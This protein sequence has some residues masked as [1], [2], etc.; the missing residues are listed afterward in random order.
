V[1]SLATLSG[2]WRGIFLTPLSGAIFSTLLFALFAGGVLKG[3][4]FP[5]I[6]SVKT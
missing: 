1:H 4:I 5:E 3:S 2:G 6:R